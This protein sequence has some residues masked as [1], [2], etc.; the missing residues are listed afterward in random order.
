MAR[1]IAVGRFV[2]CRDVVSGGGAQAQGVLGLIVDEDE[3]T[4]SVALRAGVLENEASACTRKKCTS[5]GVEH[6]LEFEQ[7]V[8]KDVLMDPAWATSL[9][10]RVPPA[11]VVNRCY[12][13]STA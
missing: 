11:H 10:T 7:V 12:F 13:T 6:T 5:D 1:L 8:A 2:G 4:V 9:E 3:E